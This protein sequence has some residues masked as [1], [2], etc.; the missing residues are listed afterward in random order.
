M[1]HTLALIRQVHEGDKKA[2]EQLVEEN[3][4]L[5]Y[6]VAQRFL[7]RGCDREDLIQIGSIGL[8]KAIDHFDCTFEV[9]FSIYSNIYLSS[10]SLST[11]MNACCGISTLPT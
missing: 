1:E 11:L 7:G 4:G 9:R 3:M 8:L 5:V 2:R 10:S 6:T